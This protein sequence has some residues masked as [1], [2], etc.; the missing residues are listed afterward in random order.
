[1]HKRVNPITD[2]AFVQGDVRSDGY[3]FDG[4][5]NIINP[6]GFVRE[7]W[8][9]PDIFYKYRRN[10]EYERINTLRDYGLTRDDFDAILEHQKG[11]CA[12]CEQPEVG[13]KGN[14]HIDHDH[15]T[16]EIRGLLCKDCNTTLGQMKDNP[17]LLRKAAAYLEAGGSGHGV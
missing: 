7:R 8:L 15:N 12:I 11:V 2:K 16:G 14:L 5:T 3:M 13:K 9:R 17:D 1:M 10:P 6:N 4:Y